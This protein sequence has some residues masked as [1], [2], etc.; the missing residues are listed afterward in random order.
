MQKLQWISIGGFLLDREWPRKTFDQDGLVALGQNMKAYGQQVPVIC[1]PVDDKQQL[2]DGARRVLAAKLVG[3]EQVLAMVLPEKP[4]AA[5][6]HIVQ[7]SLEAHKVGLSPWERSCFLHRIKEDNGWQVS[8][9]AARMHMKQPLV[10]KLLSHQ[11]LDKSLQIL[12]KRP[13]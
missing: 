3:I 7:M 4:D 13:R 10:S 2:C 12:R 5:K 6:L 8:E 9:L 1:Y 11:R